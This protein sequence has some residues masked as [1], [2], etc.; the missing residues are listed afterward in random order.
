MRPAA[1]GG[2]I[3]CGTCSPGVDYISISNLPVNISPGQ[4]GNTFNVSICDDMSLEMNQTANLTLTEP[5]NATLLDPTG[6]LT[7]L[8]NE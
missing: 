5:S 8:D 4:L 1:G 2:A 7:I 3:G 6:V